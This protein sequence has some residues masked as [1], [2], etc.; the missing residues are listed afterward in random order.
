MS[1]WAGVDRLLGNVAQVQRIRGLNGLM[2]GRFP[3][4]GY[5]FLT[6]EAQEAQ[7]T[8]DFSTERLLRLLRLLRL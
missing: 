7:E 4:I 8:L 1:H 3:F 6:Q 2:K 5:F